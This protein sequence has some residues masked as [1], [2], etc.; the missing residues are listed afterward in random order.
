MIAEIDGL[1]AVLRDPQHLVVVACGQCAA[2]RFDGKGQ[3]ID[4]S[5]FHPFYPWV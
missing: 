3:V 1:L 2:Q 4:D 5:D